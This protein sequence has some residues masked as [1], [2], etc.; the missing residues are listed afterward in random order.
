[1]LDTNDPGDRRHG[2]R[3]RAPARPAGR[4]GAA[5][6]VAPPRR[7]SRLIRTG[8]STGA[9]SICSMPPTSARGIEEAA[10]TQ[11]FHVAGAP[12]VTSSFT[13]VGPAPAHQRARH[14]SPA[15]GRPPIRRA[16]AACWSSRPRRSIRPCDDPLDE[17]APLLP[18]TPYG[19]S[20]LAQDQLAE[21][22]W[23]ED[24]L[25][26]VIARPFNHAGPRQSADFVVVE[27]RASNRADRSRPGA[28]GAARR[29]SRRAPR[30]DRRARCR[31]GLR[32][33]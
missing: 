30:H 8:T 24:G 14:A 29:Q 6:R 7:H 25:D 13:S 20:K 21:R 27:F 26:V 33:C 3:R 19:L 23:R 22:A 32:A 1:M 10:P 4:S 17:N 11:V 15:R 9:P 5:R 12:Q 28:A 2:I 16:P 31:R 18:A